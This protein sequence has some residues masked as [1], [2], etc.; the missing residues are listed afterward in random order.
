M[1]KAPEALDDRRM[2]Q[3]EAVIALA[4]GLVAD[5]RAQTHGLALALDRLVVLERQ[6]R[7]RT[8]MAARQ[9]RVPAGRDDAARERERLRIGGKRARRA[10]MDVARTLKY[11]KNGQSISLYFHTLSRMCAVHFFL[12]TSGQS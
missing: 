9:P 12:R 7:E 3:C 4:P 8:V 11:P 6:I 2:Q 1:R 10:A 5:A